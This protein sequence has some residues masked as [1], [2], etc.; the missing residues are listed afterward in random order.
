MEPSPAPPHDAPA[1]PAP[2]PM[3][4]SPMGGPGGPG[5]SPMLS[6]GGGAGNQAAAVQSIKA[7]LPAIL[8]ASM[9]FAAGSKEQQA[10]LRAVQA[11]NPIFGKAEGSNMVPAGLT[12]M[13]MQAK[14]GPLSAAPPPGLQSDNTPPPGMG[15]PE[16]PGGPQ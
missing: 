14:E 4:K 15:S 3:P 1:S 11:L 10:I 2:P 16:P 12:A 5:G 13:A 6:P 8:K 7:V 9:A